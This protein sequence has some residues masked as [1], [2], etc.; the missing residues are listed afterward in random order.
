MIRFSLLLALAACGTEGTETN[1]T[2]TNSPTGD[3]TG[4]AC[5]ALCTGAGF[6]SGEE[7]DYSPVIECLCSGA[8]AGLAQEDCT[9]Y[10]AGFGIGAEDSLLS[11]E[12]VTNDKCVCDGT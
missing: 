8:G 2:G 1:P 10:C 4:G 6:D 5:D 12:A 3:P 9:T 7:F 11:T